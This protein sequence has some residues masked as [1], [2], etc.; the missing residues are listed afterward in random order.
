[1]SKKK[2]SKKDN[3]TEKLNRRLKEIVKAQA[4]SGMRGEYLDVIVGAGEPDASQ[5]KKLD[6]RLHLNVIRTDL[7][8]TGLFVI[9]VVVLLII[10]KR[11]NLELNLGIYK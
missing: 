5:P 11:S 8:K 6:Q 9:F 10:L 4:K 1:M 3:K 2:V 7:I